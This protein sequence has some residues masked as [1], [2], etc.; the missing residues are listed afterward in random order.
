MS[1]DLFMASRGAC[2]PCSGVYKGCDYFLFFFL[3]S[4]SFFFF[5]ETKAAVWKRQLCNGLA[6]K[7]ACLC[8][9]LNISTTTGFVFYLRDTDWIKFQSARNSTERKLSSFLTRNPNDHWNQ[10]TEIKVSVPF[11]HFQSFCLIQ[12]YID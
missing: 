12:M 9:C 5:F 4:S 11:I 8:F 2:H 3:S 7:S 1:N 6:Y 10:C